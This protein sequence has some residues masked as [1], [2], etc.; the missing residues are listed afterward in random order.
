MSVLP[1]SPQTC[2][3]SE[4]KLFLAQ[5]GRN[6]LV[7]WEAE[8]SVTVLGPHGCHMW[9]AGK[10]LRMHTLRLNKTIQIEKL[11][12]LGVKIFLNVKLI[13]NTLVY[14]ST[15]LYFNYFFY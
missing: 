6:D 8:S 13:N 12:S 9:F 7:S 2:L 3:I 4:Q 11:F 15:L 1:D 10:N 14:F 5:I